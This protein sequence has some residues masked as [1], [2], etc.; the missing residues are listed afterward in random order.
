[1]TIDPKWRFIIGLIVTTAIGVSSGAVV[2]TNAIPADWIKP[3]VAWCG[4]IAFIGSAAQTTISGLGMSSQSRNA[5]AAQGNTVV[6]QTN[7]PEGAAGVANRLAAMPEV[8]KVV[9]TQQLADAAPS[10]KV[11][12][13]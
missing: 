10:P 4:I 3:A 2:L 11:V 5:A 13:Q 1:M 12:S 7:S 6:V 8:N 9:A